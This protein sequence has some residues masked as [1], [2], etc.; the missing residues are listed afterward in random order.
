[1][2]IVARKNLFSERTRLAI[3]VG[4]VA[5]SVLLISLLLA[6]FRGWNEKVGGYVEDVNADVWIAQQGTVDFFT[7]L[8]VL[9][10]GQ[11]EQ[12]LEELPSAVKSYSS[13][14]AVPLQATSES[15]KTMDIEMVGYDTETGI[16]GPL[17]IVEGESEPG[18]GEM[19][20]DTALTRR[21][22][23]DV[24]DKL[25]AAGRDWTVV[26]RSTGGDFIAFRMVFVNLADAQA[27][28]QHV[29]AVTEDGKSINVE[30]VGY[31]PQT[32]EPLNVSEGKPTPGPG[33]MII[34]NALTNRFGVD[35]GDT[36]SAAGR[37]WSVAGRANG[38]ESSTVFVNLADA[39]AVIQQEGRVTYFM[40]QLKTPEKA[41]EWAGVIEFN[42]ENQGLPIVAI[43]T[44]K[45][46]QDTR[47]RVLGNVVPILTVILALAFIVGLAVAGLT[48]YTATVEKA[49]EFGILKAVGFKN[50]Y[51]YRVVFEQSLVTGILGFLI[52]VALTLILGP[53]AED[54][55]PQFVILIRWQ[56]IL[57]VLGATLLMAVLAGYV[58]TRRLAAIDPISVFRA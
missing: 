52:G 29:S 42:A 38:G 40:L 22:G 54:F 10:K 27:A 23:V 48:I 13:I 53:F 45:F 8:P 12:L 46:A 19:I 49:R 24:G 44:D 18:P 31:D 36:L 17:E 35:I 21:Y 4:G 57:A 7:A 50:R 43:P 6:L 2:L 51:L 47:D 15:G 56:D 32:G 20:V 30:L 9:P 39:E 37:E 11:G 33:E 3:S 1:M 14:V 5:L 41:A 58:P 34:N 16:G 25:N 28:I 26:G 55:V